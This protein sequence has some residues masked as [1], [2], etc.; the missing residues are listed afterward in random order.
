MA[1]T[2]TAFTKTAE[3][4]CAQL[5]EAAVDHAAFETPLLPCDLTRCRASCCH[6]GVVL[7]REE[8]DL[9]E[10]LL[11]A[12]PDSFPPDARLEASGSSN[13]SLKTATRPARDHDCAEDYP[14]HFTR[15]RCVFLDHNH[16]C[17]LQLHSSERGHHQ[18]F[19]KPI[20]CWMHPVLLQR[21][22][23][24]H[25]P[26]LTLRTTADDERRFA[27]CTHC[28]RADPSG[29]PAKDALGPELEA[30]SILSGRDFRNE[31]SAESL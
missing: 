9:I 27:S 2:P 7:S 3:A 31:L 15:T 28:G 19:F 22:A 13:G 30:L 16:R 10:N 17:T 21:S 6:D 26:V 24:D 29:M 5:R 25:R 18:W 11:Q 20:S 4:L 1:Q 14:D 8:G 12:F 23:P